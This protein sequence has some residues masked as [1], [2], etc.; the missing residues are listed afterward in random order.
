MCWTTST[1]LDLWSMDILCIQKPC[2]AMGQYLLYLRGRILSQRQD[3]G[4]FDRKPTASWSPHSP[5]HVEP[6][7]RDPQPK[8]GYLAREL[9]KSHV[10]MEKRRKRQVLDGTGSCSLSSVCRRLSRVS[11]KTYYTPEWCPIQTAALIKGWY[12]ALV[13]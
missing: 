6:L 4:H 5:P 3:E 8:E 7:W 2:L 9:R 10:A 13:G 1:C 12:S 11:Q